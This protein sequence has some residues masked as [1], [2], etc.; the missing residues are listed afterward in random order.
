MAALRAPRPHDELGRGARAAGA[1]QALRAGRATTCSRS[2]TTGSAATR[3]RPSASLVL[4]SAELNCVLPGERDGHVL[5]F[6]IDDALETLEG[7]R[8]DLAGTAGVDHRARRRRLPRPSR[9]GRARSRD[10]S[11]C[12]TPSRGSRSTTPAASSRSAAASRRCTG[13]SCSTAGR[14]ASRSPPTTATTRASTPTS[15]GPGSAPSRPWR[16]CSRRCAQGCFYGTHGA[17][18]HRRSPR[19][20]ARSRCSATRAAAS[21]SSSASRAAPPSTRA[22]SATATAARSSRRRRTG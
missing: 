4:P 3:R 22:G 19:G 7:E 9:T 8:R 2:P 16:A 1:R 21:R 5:A 12:R 20:T 14:R 13:T 17:A 15:R 6:G 10:R 11:S 18:H